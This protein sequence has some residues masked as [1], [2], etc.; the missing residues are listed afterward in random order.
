[1][2]PTKS[3]WSHTYPRAVLRGILAD[4][5]ETLPEARRTPSLM[6]CLAEKILILAADGQK[7]PIDLRRVAIKRVQDSCPDCR[8]CDGLQLTQNRGGSSA[9]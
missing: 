1:M 6:A 3:E 2:A 4:A 9:S 5:A 7:N 8:A